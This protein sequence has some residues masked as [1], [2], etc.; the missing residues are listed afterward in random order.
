[1]HDSTNSA[2]EVPPTHEIGLY[3]HIPF[4]SHKCFYCDFNSGPLSSTER[5]AYL[6]ALTGEITGSPWRGHTAKTVSFGGGTPSELTRAELGRLVDTLCQT[7]VLKQ[8]A[9]WSIE[10]NPGGLSPGFLVALLEM[11]FNRV[12]L[13]VQS[14]HAHH[15]QRLGGTHHS[16]DARA[17]YRW[18]REAGCDNVNLDLIFGLPGQTLQEWQ[19][20]LHEALTLSP[21]H[22]SI[23]NHSI[24]PGTDFGSRHASGEL[25]EIEEDLFA[26][27][28]E[29]AMELTQAAGYRQYEISHYSRPWAAVWFGW[30]HEF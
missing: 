16:A 2:P 30:Q 23:Y 1:M 28:Y 22:L 4:C 21:E 5:Q 7:F 12:S 6:A 29:L 13:R 24:E 25:Q 17:A 14:F 18:L 20:D 19:A 11:G 15:L 27:M 26:D 10:C 8:K 9:E 3:L